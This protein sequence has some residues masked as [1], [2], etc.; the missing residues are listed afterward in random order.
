MGGG[1]RGVRRAAVVVGR[2]TEQARLLAAVHDVRTGGSSTLFLLGE[3]GVGK[4]RLLSEVSAECRRV[5][6]AVFSGRAPVTAPVPF[7]VLAEALRSWLRSQ[8]A[9]PS[10]RRAVS[11]DVPTK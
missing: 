2:A 5:G 8:P 4:T 3:G 1:G 7:S 11:H 6:V 9:V 10:L